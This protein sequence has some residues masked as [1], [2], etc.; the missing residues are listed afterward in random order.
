M[1]EVCKTKPGVTQLLTNGLPGWL[2]EILLGLSVFDYL[3][4]CH[5][6]RKQLIKQ[7][8]RCPRS[9]KKWKHL[10]KASGMASGIPSGTQC[11]RMQTNTL[12]F[13][14]KVLPN[15]KSNIPQTN[16]LGV[17][18]KPHILYT[19]IYISASVQQ[20]QRVLWGDQASQ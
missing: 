5:T 14:E 7:F 10:E 11:F 18:F 9:D 8:R 15:Y 19:H 12:L 16:W 2:P 3:L 1:Y 13:E 6:F 20:V 17:C 4:C